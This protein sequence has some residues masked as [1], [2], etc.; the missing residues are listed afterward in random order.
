MAWDEP[1]SRRAFLTRGALLSS[2]ILTGSVGIPS[3][4]FR[5]PAADAAIMGIGQEL[6]DI[7]NEETVNRILVE[8][9][10]RG[11]DF[12]DVFAEQRFRTDIVLDQGAIASVTYG[13]PR[14]AGVRVVRRN[15]I[16]YAFADEIGYGSLLDAARIASSVVE[17]Q[18]P[19]TPIDVT[20][21]NLP[22]P[23]AIADPEPLMN[24][25]TKFD[26]LMRMDQ[27]A[28]AVDPRIASVRIAYMD[29]V[30][31]ILIGSSD[32]RYV[33][34]RQ[35]LFSASV[36]ATALANG[37]RRTGY[38]RPGGRR[39]R[40]VFE[41]GGSRGDRPDR[42]AAGDHAPRGG[43]G[44]RGPDAGRDR[45]RLGRRPGPRVARSRERGRRGS[46]AARRSSPA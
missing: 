6:R 18:S 39:R 41:P 40:D 36:T 43:A 30:R 7:L 3:L 8:S 45:P 24:E 25:L 42:R 34:D 12:A 23:F 46:G 5:A 27:A 11:G 13:Y 1:L 20:R 44:A 17:N 28:R 38:R 26:L 31:D 33:I 15:Q 16:G 4:L 37:E 29:E 10:R 19:V 2:A 21:R 35:F 14:G 32:G 9:L 22:Q